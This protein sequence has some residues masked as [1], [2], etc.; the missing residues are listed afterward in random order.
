MTAR[1][2]VNVAIGRGL[3]SDK[4][5]G[6]TPHQ[7]MKA[8]ITVDIRRRGDASPF[9]RTAPGRFFLRSLVL[10]PTS[11]YAAPP[12]RA[13]EAKEHVLVFPTLWLDAEDR[14]QGIPSL[15][16]S[17]A[18]LARLLKA[19]VFDYRDRREAE[20]SDDVKQVLTY[21]LVTRG[22]RLLAFKRGVYSRAEDF[23]K[24][25]HC[26]GF[27]GH[28]ALGDRDLFG[29]ADFGIA[30]CAARELQEE[31]VLPRPDRDR[32]TRLEGLRVVGILNDDSSPNGR[33]HF[34]VVMRYEVTRH[35]AW[36]SPRANERSVTQLRWI[37]PRKSSN[38][39]FDFEYWSQLCLLR[40]YSG[41]EITRPYYRVYRRTLLRPPHILLVIGAI[42]SGKSELTSVLQQDFSYVEINSGRVLARELGIPAVAEKRRVA[43]QD[44]AWTYI[45][46]PDGPDRFARALLREAER[47]DTPR[48]LIDGIRHERTLLALKRLAAPRRVATIYV[49]TPINVAFE[50]FRSRAGPRATIHDFLEVRGAPVEQDVQ[51]LIRDADA[52]VFN[53]KG[54]AQYRSIIRT[55]MRE[56]GVEGRGRRIR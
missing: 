39:L 23:L 42:G 48:I 19:G 54:R 43:F 31:L 46:A 53:W 24:G 26:V 8:K 41:A 4:V 6:R 47:P 3:F 1:D 32:L 52:V 22:E 21:V 27:G 34:A 15:A 12:L 2:L 14:F 45:T 20:A 56:I 29:L 35:P 28:V 13:P 37:D 18:V 33:R 49:H 10:D 17:R 40:Y 50:F 44:A 38:V 5:A 9:V 36:D 30:A 51:R 25:S 11:I 16:R 55:L 7:T